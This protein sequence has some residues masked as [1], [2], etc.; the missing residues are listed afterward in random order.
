LAIWG[1]SFPFLNKN[2]ERARQERERR[3]QEDEQLAKQQAEAEAERQKRIEQ[4]WSQQQVEGVEED[5]MV[6]QRHRGSVP[7]T[8]CSIGTTT[9][10]HF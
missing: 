2:A 3:K 4:Q 1:N 8:R 9:G 7:K 5:K 10:K 6:E